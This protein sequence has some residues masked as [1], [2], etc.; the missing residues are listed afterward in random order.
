MKDSELNDYAAFADKN[1]HTLY[2]LI[3]PS[4]N[5]LGTTLDWWRL[6]SYVDSMI[7]YLIIIN[8][9]QSNPNLTPATVQ[10]LQKT[11]QENKNF[12][13]DVVK[14]FV[15]T[16]GCNWFDDPCWW[17]IAFTNGAETALSLV[18]PGRNG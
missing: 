3:W 12:Y 9:L 18:E 16:Y 14:L 6:G 1:F 7:D 2:T 5:T 15:A 13:D 10:T 11:L 8:K 17:G 4:P